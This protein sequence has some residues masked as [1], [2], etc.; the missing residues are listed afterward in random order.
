MQAELSAQFL[1]NQLMPDKA[2]RAILAQ[3]ADAGQGWP[4]NSCSTS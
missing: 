2:G 3:L 1:L 4:H